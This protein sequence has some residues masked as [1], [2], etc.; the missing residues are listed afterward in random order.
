MG[1]KVGWGISEGQKRKEKF[2]REGVKTEVCSTIPSVTIRSCGIPE[3]DEALPRFYFRVGAFIL[4]L[5]FVVA[6]VTGEWAWATVE[7]VAMTVAVVAG[8][9]FMAAL[10]LGMVVGLLWTI[11]RVIVCGVWSLLGR[12]RSSRC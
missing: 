2:A 5:S 1:A 8:L 6:L 3:V 10:V 4:A 7:T 12:G 9:L 11:G